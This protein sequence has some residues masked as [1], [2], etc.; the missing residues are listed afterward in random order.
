MFAKGHEHTC[1]NYNP[2]YWKCN[3]KGPIG[4]PIIKFKTCPLVDSTF[5]EQI[6]SDRENFPDEFKELENI[7]DE[8]ITL[9][10]KSGN[11]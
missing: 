9:L 7:I 10:F 8:G 6:D 5:Q 2:K 4:E 3:A 1:P 11:K